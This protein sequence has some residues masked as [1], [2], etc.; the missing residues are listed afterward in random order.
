MN[1]NIKLPL[2]N[3]A[4]KGRNFWELASIVSLMLILYVLALI[5]LGHVGIWVLNTLFPVL[6][7]AYGFDEVLAMVLLLIVLTMGSNR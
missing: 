4:V 2:F 7:I 5:A 6:G 3:L 1:W